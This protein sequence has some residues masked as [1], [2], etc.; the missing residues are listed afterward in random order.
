MPVPSVDVVVIGAGPAGA[1]SARLLASWGRSVVVVGRAPR[2]RALAES[3]PPSCAKLLERVG[4]LGAVDAAGFVRA[5]GNTVKWAGA[6][7]R[8]EFFDEGTYG[9]QVPRADFDALLL[10]LA[11]R[12]SAVVHRDATVRDVERSAGEWV[13]GVDSPG[14]RTV[15][16]SAWLLDC[17]GRSGVIARRGW[18]KAESSSR[19]MALV[20]VWECDATREFENSHTLVESYDGGWAWSVPVASGR[21]YVTAMLDPSITTLP[22]KAQLLEAYRTEL[23]RTSMLRSLVRSG[24]LVEPPWGCDASPYT[25]EQFA[26]DQALL[27]GDAGSFVD[28]LSSFG[29]KKAL[30]SAWLAAVV[31]N[32]AFLDAAMSTHALELFAIR[33]RAMYEQLRRQSAAVSREAAGAHP[34]DFW[35]GRSEMA[36]EETLSGGT[37]DVDV[38]ALRSDPRVLRAFE[39]L[40]R[41]P[42]LALRPSRTL[43]IVERATVRDRRV[44]LSRHLASPQVPDGIRYCRNVDLLIIAQIA[45]AHDQVPDLFDAY[46]RLAPP[47]ALPD[48]LGA[49]STLV[50]L[51][52]LVLA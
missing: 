26:G 40:K 13:V 27:V 24:T 48:F 36:L 30:A 47:A 22:G 5:T 50:G 51:G 20:A 10:S 46:N 32:T 7:T 25:A 2:R 11:E 29:V 4:V 44:V 34:T 33:E 37:G 14:G 23:E 9:Y 45:S 49:L 18:R 21:R 1:A 43:N 17:T 15:I 39:E 41:R 8:V 16:R 38:A 19:T 3:L 6:E 52:F 35:R 31:V 28:P 12:A 42:S